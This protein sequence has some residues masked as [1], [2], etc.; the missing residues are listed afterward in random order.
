[1]TVAKN[2]VKTNKQVA[3]KDIPIS[4]HENALALRLKKKEEYR[5]KE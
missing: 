4:S 3:K 5:K 2:M 1:M